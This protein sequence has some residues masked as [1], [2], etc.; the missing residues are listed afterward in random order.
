MQ[1]TSRGRQPIPG[2]ISFLKQNR[3][4]QLA[5]ELSAIESE[6]SGIFLTVRHLEGLRRL[7]AVSRQA[8]RGASDSQVR[9]IATIAEQSGD[10]ARAIDTLAAQ[11]APALARN[12]LPAILEQLGGGLLE[13]IGRAGVQLRPE[14]L[15]RIT[16]MS[17]YRATSTL[18]GGVTSRGTRIPGLLDDLAQ[19]LTTVTEAERAIRAIEFP[20][21]GAELFARWATTNLEALRRFNPTVA[22]GIEAIQRVRPS[23]AIGKIAAIHRELGGHQ[24][25]LDVFESL[26]VVQRRYG[27]VPGFDRLVAGLAAGGN[28]TRGSL[29]ILHVTSRRNIGTITGFEVA[30]EVAGLARNRVYDVVTNRISWEFKY[31]LGFGGRP[32]TAA[33]DEFARDVVLHAAS[34]FRNLRWA[35][36]REAATQLPA[37]ESMMRGVLSRKEVRLALRGQRISAAEAMRRLEAALQEGLIMTF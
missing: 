3:P 4:P 9:L 34:G 23:D 15:Q 26:A 17:P 2:L 37:I 36:S 24:V 8:L 19:R 31:W 6:F 13:T 1:G 28:T 32:A 29:F 7:N 35:I 10:A 12:Q 18:L 11:L 30:Q 25:A 16:R 33:A 22:E 5:A 27:A 20:G 21:L 14:L